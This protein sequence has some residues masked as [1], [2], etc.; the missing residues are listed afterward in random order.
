[1]PGVLAVLTGD[2]ALVATGRGTGGSRSMP[3]G[4]V[5][6][7]QAAPDVGANGLPLAAELLEAA[8]ADIAFADGSYRVVGTDKAVS[9]GDVA[10]RADEGGLA[11]HAAWQPS[12]HTFPNGCHVCEIGVDIA[13]GRSSIER[14]TA[15][16][17]FGTVI[18]PLLVEGEVQGGVAQGIGQALLEQ[19][20]YDPGSGQLL[21]GS[22]MD[23]AMPR[24]D[25]APAIDFSML[26]VPCRTNPMGMKGP[27]RR[28]PSARRRL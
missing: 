20:V 7:R 6:V 5:A 26:P 17:D 27:A 4:G 12:I 28:A 19:E 16:D 13:T 24:A 23:Y 11:G 15:V 21:S 10:R 25:T 22:F 3:V 18:T 8:A 1:M 14:Y 9:L 2:T